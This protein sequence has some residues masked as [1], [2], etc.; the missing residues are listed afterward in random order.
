MLNL[1]E[2]K[3]FNNNGYVSYYIPEHHLAGKSGIVYEHM[4]MAEELLGREL[5][6]GETVHHKDRD[7]YNNSLNNLM[8]FKTNADHAAYH[9]GCDIVLDGDVYVAVRTN[10]KS[11]N[12]KS[13]VNEC[14][15]CGKEKCSEAKLCME[16]FNKEASK[17]IPPK[18]EVIDKL[19]NYNMLTIGKMYG[20]SDN[21]VRRWCRKYELPYKRKDI[22]EF[23]K[24][25]AIMTIVS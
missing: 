18:E 16:C 24:N 1:N 5:N 4:L 6:D 20:V 10:H 7:R 3:K 12:F 8:V 13:L 11:A 23:R 14:P 15:I 22:E 19:L 2:L 25:H 17:N 9:G 21:A